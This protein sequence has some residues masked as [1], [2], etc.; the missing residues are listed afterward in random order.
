MD[1]IDACVG[2]ILAKAED[3][4]RKAK[5]AGGIYPKRD[6]GPLELPETAASSRM[7]DP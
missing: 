6:K 4:E 5:N 3:G 2:L 1:V 7:S